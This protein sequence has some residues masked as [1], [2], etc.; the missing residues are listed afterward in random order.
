MNEMMPNLIHNKK[1]FFKVSFYN[2][3][4]HTG[5]KLPNNST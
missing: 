1:I 3:A 2:K 5:E 4:T